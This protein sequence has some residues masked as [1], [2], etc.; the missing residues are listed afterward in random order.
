[1]RQN[2][3]L[4]AELL[5]A[6]GSLPTPAALFSAIRESTTNMV[7]LLIKNRADVNA[8]ESYEQTP[9]HEA[10]RSLTV[11]NAKLLLDHY[12]GPNLRNAGGETPLDL[13]KEMAHVG[14]QPYRPGFGSS[15][16]SSDYV[17]PVAG[18]LVILLREHGARD[19]LP[20]LD[21]IEV[22]RPSSGYSNLEFTK[23]T[24]DWNHFSLLEALACQYRIISTQS[25]GGVESR[26]G[27]GHA[28]WS[29]NL[30]YPNLENL[31]I[32][33]PSPDGKG[34]NDV[35]V[36]ALELLATGDCA[37]RCLAPMGGYRR[38]AQN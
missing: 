26:R 21:R 38:N 33:R 24:N 9:L 14:S 28:I 19:D 6:H 23:G 30:D 32:H 35:R 8:R 22:K 10:V 5:I 13:A 18:E 27:G 11:A 29:G 7:E 15:V 20:H 36:N 4:S 25:S 31:I 3:K 16:K 1:M 34:W 2:K 37:S 12:A 17:R